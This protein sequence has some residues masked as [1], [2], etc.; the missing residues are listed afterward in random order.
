MGFNILK[1]YI[2]KTAAKRLISPQR[3]GGKVPLECKSVSLSPFYVKSSGIIEGNRLEGLAR[4][5]NGGEN[6]H[7]PCN[8]KYDNP[9]MMWNYLMRGPGMTRIWPDARI[10]TVYF[11]SV[12]PLVVSVSFWNDSDLPVNH[13]R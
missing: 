4:F 12:T 2:Y 3:Q 8:M 10:V 5:V 11:M 7:N 13:T 1:I 9:L 6:Y